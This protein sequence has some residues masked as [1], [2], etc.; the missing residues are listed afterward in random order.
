[1]PRSGA[2][3]RFSTACRVVDKPDIR[4]RSA[5]L[6][7]RAKAMG[8]GTRR[9]SRAGLPCARVALD[10]FLFM[11]ASAATARQHAA[12][13]PPHLPMAEGFRH[14]TSF[15]AARISISRGRFDGLE[16]V[17]EVSSARRLD[18]LIGRAGACHAITLFNLRATAAC[19]DA[20]G[21]DDALG[22]MRR[23][24]FSARHCRC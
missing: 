10:A 17:A 2:V 20:S 6:R 23:S 16:L 1:M 24:A 7:F 14:C 12:R 21:F 5:S 19:R 13:S 3:S 18:L 8:E 4:R 11:P 9:A 22:A 15:S